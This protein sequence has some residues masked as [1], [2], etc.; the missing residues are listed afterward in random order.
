LTSALFSAT[1]I[2]KGEVYVTEY[3]WGSLVS[4]TEKRPGYQLLAVGY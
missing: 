3:G 1:I 2:D 4:Q